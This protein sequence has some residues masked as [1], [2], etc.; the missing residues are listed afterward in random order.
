MAAI[1]VNQTIR[2]DEEG[3]T[4]KTSAWDS[5]NGGQFTLLTHLIKPNYLVVLPPTQH[6]SFFR[7][8]PPLISHLVSQSATSCTLPWTLNLTLCLH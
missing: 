8:L 6:Y 5:L 3:L 4:L 7:N 2:S 1:L